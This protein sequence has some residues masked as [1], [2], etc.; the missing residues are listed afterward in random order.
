MKDKLRVA[1]DVATL[2]EAKALV[3]RLYPVV[4]IFKVGSQLFTGYGPEAVRFIQQKGAKVFLDLKFHD[5]PNTVA[6]A[7]AQAKN[8]GVFMVN[9]H[10]LGGKGMMRAAVC[11]K[12]KKGPI[13]L[14][15][16]VL[17]SMDK[18][19]LKEV[20]VNKNPLAQVKKLALLAKSSGIDGVVCSANEALLVRRCCGKKFVIVTP[21]IRLPSEA[22]Q[23]QK[24][25]AT[26]SYALKQGADFIVVGR[27]IIE[28]KDPL[29][30]AREVL[31][32]C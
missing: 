31:S 2:K 18:N 27:P 21:G 10:S 17:T 20:G 4:K 28:A 11:A 5:I 19:T 3:D 32:T 25:V 29:A 13:I 7:V 15:V 14:A 24:R 30:A 22:R 26:P 6:N 8:M 1:L 16:T 12:A 23:D 9:L